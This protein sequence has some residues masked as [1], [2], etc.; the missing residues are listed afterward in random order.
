MIRRC[1]TQLGIEGLAADYATELT[2][3][4]VLGPFGAPSRASPLLRAARPQGGRTVI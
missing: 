3:Q 1:S 4:V 2:G